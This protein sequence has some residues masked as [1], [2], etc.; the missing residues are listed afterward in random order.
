MSMVD[1]GINLKSGTLDSREFVKYREYIEDN[2]INK[3]KTQFL[4]YELIKSKLPLLPESLLIWERIKTIIVDLIVEKEALNE[5]Q[6]D[7]EKKREMNGALNDMRKRNTREDVH[8]W[9]YQGK[10][11]LQVFILFYHYPFFTW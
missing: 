4:E 10:S 3:S 7:M 11:L 9:L 2:T 5:F 1:S 6:L 8:E